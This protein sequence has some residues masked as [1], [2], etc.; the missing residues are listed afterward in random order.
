MGWRY[1]N[2]ACCWRRREGCEGLGTSPHIMR[3]DTSMPWIQVLISYLFVES[4]PPLWSQAWGHADIFRSIQHSHP[5][6]HLWPKL[7]PP[8]SMILDQMLGLLESNLLVLMTSWYWRLPW[9]WFLWTAEGSASSPSQVEEQLTP[10]LTPHKGRYIMAVFFMKWSMT[11]QTGNG[12][13]L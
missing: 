1:S 4:P 12:I 8:T 5:G 11:N 13:T 9:P 7:L 6:A 3:T 2:Q 10:G